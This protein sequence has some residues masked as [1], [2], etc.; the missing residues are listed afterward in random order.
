MVPA[1]RLVSIAASQI[2]KPYVFGARVRLDDP[3]PPS[4]DCAEFASWVVY[5]A[6]QSTVGTVGQGDPYSGAWLTAGERIK[7]AEA[8]ALRGAFLVRAPGPG[9]IGHVVLSAGL[10]YTIEA[11]SKARGV[12]RA[13]ANGR[14]WDAGILIEGVEYERPYP[15]AE[16]PHPLEAPGSILRRGSRGEAVER[17]QRELRA[18]GFDVEI[19][20]RFGPQTE[21]A[22]EAFQRANGGL[23]ADGEVGP[24]TLRALAL[25][26]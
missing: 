2:G 5:Q 8:A 6:T 13:S 10:G 9:K 12:C 16:F 17:V 19:D 22:V 11:H 3:D 23:V 20:G 25:V 18:R 1:S 26:L 15:G 4:F 24:K 14:R 21:A 7:P